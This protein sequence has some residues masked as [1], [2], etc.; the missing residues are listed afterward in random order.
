LAARRPSARRLD[1]AP[2]E[3]VAGAHLPRTGLSGAGDD[4]GIGGVVDAG[5]GRDRGSVRPERV[6]AQGLVRLGDVAP[7]VVGY[8]GDVAGESGG[9]GRGWPHSVTSRP[10]GGSVRLS[11]REPASRRGLAGRTPEPPAEPGRDTDRAC[12]TLAT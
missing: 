9:C 5:V 11:A 4:A 3:S 7:G 10:R 6:G 12:G 1:H 2:G 8:W